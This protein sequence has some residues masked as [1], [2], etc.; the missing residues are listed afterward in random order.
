MRVFHD[1][2]LLTVID[3]GATR[4]TLVWEEAPSYTKALLS[5]CLRDLLCCYPREVLGMPPTHKDGRSGAIA[6]QRKHRRKQMRHL[7]SVAIA[8]ANSWNDFWNSVGDTWRN[9]FGKN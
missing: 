6:P 8:K 7:K 3:S 5:L 9:I 2:E 4:A 1:D